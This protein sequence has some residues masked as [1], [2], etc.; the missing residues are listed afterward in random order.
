ML[1]LWL[2]HFALPGRT[3]GLN[4][5]PV[6]V[7]KM[8]TTGHVLNHYQDQRL[9]GLQNRLVPKSTTNFQLIFV[10]HVFAPNFLSP[11]YTKIISIYAVNS[12]T[13]NSWWWIMGRACG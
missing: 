11:H 3:Q 8:K 7:G 1:P 10:G 5:Y 13:M 4:P 6:I 9:A 2:P 12:T